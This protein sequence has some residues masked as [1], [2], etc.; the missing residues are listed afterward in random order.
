MMRQLLLVVVGLITGLPAIGRPLTVDEA[1]DLALENSHGIEMAEAGEAKAR[2]EVQ[3]AFLAF[4]PSLNASAGYTRLD[5]VPYVEFDM[6]AMTG[7]DGGGDPCA[8]INVEDLPVGWTVEM[9]QGMCYMMMGWMAGDPNA[10]PAQISMGLKDNYFA[11]LTLEQVV[12]A[13]GAMHQSYAAS[14]DLRSSAAEQVRLAR[15]QAAYDAESGFYQ[16]ILA[17]KAVEVTGEAQ[18]LMDAYVGQLQSVVD[19]GAGNMADLLAAKSQAASARLDAMRTAHGAQIAERFFKVNVGLPQEEYIELVLDESSRFTELP[20]PHEDLLVEAINHRPDLASVDDSLKAMRHY[21]GATWASWLPAI[22]LMGNLNFKNPNYALEP[23]WYGS[24]DVTVVANWALWDRGQALKRGSA[25]AASIAQ[26]KSQR[27][28]LAEM[29][30][31]EVETAA[32]SFEEALAELDVADIGLQA[33][34]EA[35][36]LEHE[37]FENGV[38]NNT[39]LLAAHAARSGAKLSMLQAETQL[40]I[41]HA[42]LRKA[43]G[44]DPEV[45]P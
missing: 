14:R 12:F 6:G 2:A 4:F 20:F 29:M 33:S 34:E 42:A 22:I 41:S 11:K 17:R 25:M 36:R 8:N 45:N 9:A 43:L 28:L 39:Q 31:V 38:S 40:R 13:G 24:A 32:S 26:L 5:Q 21:R 27:E 10:E 3:E 1:V 7:S 30:G 37:R 15:Q 35:Y 19:V 44:V 16:L 23:E 18:E